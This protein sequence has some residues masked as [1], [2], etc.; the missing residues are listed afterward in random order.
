MGMAAILLYG[1]DRL[2][3]LIIQQKAQCEIW[4]KLVELYR[5]DS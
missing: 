2:N 1:A 3:K 4:W 5:E